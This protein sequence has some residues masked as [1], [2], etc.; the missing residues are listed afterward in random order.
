MHNV[1]FVL[2]LGVMK[3]LKIFGLLLIVL[4]AIFLLMGTLVPKVIYQTETTINASRHKVWNEFNDISNVS[5]WMDGI[6][7]VEK[8]VVTPDTIGSKYRMK[9]EEE[10]NDVIVNELVTGYNRP[11]MLSLHFDID[12]MTKDDTY[13]FIENNGSTIIQANHVFESETYLGKCMFAVM[14]SLF[15]KRDEK[16]LNQ[17]KKYVEQQ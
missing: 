11:E 17:F 6:T 10:G 1:I 2:Q 9:V 5:K 15:I 4:L 3:V 12:Q 8:I 7:E 16:H 14:K 13:K